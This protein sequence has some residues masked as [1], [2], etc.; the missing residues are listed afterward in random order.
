MT[1]PDPKALLEQLEA[2]AK[3]PSLEGFAE[4]GIRQ[5]L[6]EATRQISVALETPGDVV[7]RIA[8]TV[9]YPSCAETSL[10]CIC[11]AG[12]PTWRLEC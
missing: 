11:A 7:H 9:Q 1:L 10:H 6:R 3:Q 5:R 8:N 12:W 2:L 4:E